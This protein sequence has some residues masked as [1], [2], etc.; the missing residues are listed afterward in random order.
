MR[1]VGYRTDRRN[2]PKKKRNASYFPKPAS[3]FFTSL[4]P[5]GIIWYIILYGVKLLYIP[6]LFSECSYI[7]VYMYVLVDRHATQDIPKVQG[8]SSCQPWGRL[9]ARALYIHYSWIYVSLF[10]SLS[11]SYCTIIYIFFSFTY[12][13]FQGYFELEGT[14]RD[15]SSSSILSSRR[16]ISASMLSSFSLNIS[17]YSWSESER[18]GIHLDSAIRCIKGFDVLCAFSICHASTR[19]K[20]LWPQ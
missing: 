18:S 6:N 8:R 17:L 10:Y 1:E 16:A 20:T 15:F 2:W 11:S 3:F 9:Q 19:L 13:A 4:W 5:L 7:V 12:P 14:G